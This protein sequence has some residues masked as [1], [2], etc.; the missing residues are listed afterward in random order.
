MNNGFCRRHGA[1][2]TLVELMVTIV[3]A[4]ILIA[5]AMPSYQAQIRK[6][7]RTEAKT[8]ALDAAVRE[9]RFYATQNHYSSDSTELGYTSAGNA[10]PFVAGTYYQISV[11][12]GDV[13]PATADNPGLFKIQVTPAPGSPQAADTACQ[14]FMV[15]Q[16]GEKTAEGTGS[17]PSVTCWQ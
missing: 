3:I 4:T 11:D 10:F 13:Q 7:R 16:K 1:G 9:E 5:I 15:D 6:S 12:P 8:M 2:F 17:N 14:K